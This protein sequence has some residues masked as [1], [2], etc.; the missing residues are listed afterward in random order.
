MV[1]GSLLDALRAR[2]ALAIVR[3]SDRETALR[4]IEVLVEE[5]IDLVEVSLTAE[6]AVSVI[7]DAVARF[8]RAARIGAGTVRTVAQL[9][10]AVAAGAEFVVSPGLGAGA[11]AAREH[12][13][14]CL[15]GVLTATELGAG[16]EAGFDALKLF[17]A[18]LGGPAHVRA[19]RD[20]FPDARLVP[21]GGVGLDA[22]GDYLDAGALA[23]GI[24]GPLL[25]DA[26]H[27]GPLDALRERA[28]TLAAALQGR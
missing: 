2:R 16:I 1:T 6:V 8:G 7:A 5:G 14:D 10:A 15:P 18:S 13:V 21:V 27:G 23:V 28:R 17:P 19:L 25:G 9:D 3:G 22:V 12:G 11:L 24:G 20:P 4:C 26:P